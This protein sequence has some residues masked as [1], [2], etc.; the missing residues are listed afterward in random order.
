MKNNVAITCFFLLLLISGCIGTKDFPIKGM[1]WSK[2]EVSKPYT[3]NTSYN[4]TE[5]YL[6]PVHYADTEQYIDNECI[7][8]PYNVTECIQQNL[9]F[10]ITN[11]RCWHGMIQCTP[12]Q[13][14]VG[15]TCTINNTDSVD[16]NFTVYV[17][18]S[19][20]ISQEG[21]NQTLLV[22]SQT[23]RNFRYQN[24][25]TCKE[26]THGYNPNPTTPDVM[27]FCVMQSVPTKEVCSD[28]VKTKQECHEVTKYRNVLKYRDETR[29]RNITKYREE[30]RYQ[31]VEEVC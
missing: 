6:W 2:C 25:V 9:T 10:S 26:T 19:T 24:E 14:I 7:S 4:E 28:V 16:G 20:S 11:Q 31:I 29:S 27:C 12:P 5:Y 13:L 30:T 18:F 22:P 21:E 8:I 3:E 17:G 1:G 23:S 15:S